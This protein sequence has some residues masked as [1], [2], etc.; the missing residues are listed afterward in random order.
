MRFSNETYDKIFPRQEE[1]PTVESAVETFKPTEQPVAEVEKVVE[2]VETVEE[3][4]E[5]DTDERYSESDTE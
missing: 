4:E 5:V 1:R 2:D 3:E